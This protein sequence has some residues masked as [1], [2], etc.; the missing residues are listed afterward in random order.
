M[1]SKLPLLRNYLNI[2]ITIELNVQLCL[3]NLNQFHNIYLFK[4]LFISKSNFYYSAKKILQF[5][6]SQPLYYLV[7]YINIIIF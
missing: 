3:R 2:F 5:I 7:I 1:I 4:C 6:K